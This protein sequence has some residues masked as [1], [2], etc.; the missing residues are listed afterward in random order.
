MGEECAIQKPVGMISL[1]D[2]RN[3]DIM[4]VIREVMAFKKEHPKEYAEARERSTGL[5][6]CRHNEMYHALVP[7]L[8]PTLEEGYK[9]DYACILEDSGRLG[10]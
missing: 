2:I 3:M 1:D 7:H 5:L 6:E 10:K 8:I 9:M 4:D